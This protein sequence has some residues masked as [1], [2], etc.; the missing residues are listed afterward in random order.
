VEV[1]TKG[2]TTL[3][4]SADG[5]A[6]WVKKGKDAFFGH[7]AYVAVDTEDAFIDTAMARPANKSE[8]KQ[9]RRVVRSLPEG[10]EGVL[11]DKGFASTA[12]R[13][14]LK[15]KRLDDLIQYRATTPRRLSA[16][17]PR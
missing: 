17:R 12:N 3:K 9:F 6:R 15:R 7:R 10:V 4:D 11:A 13:Q 1:D 2:K 5:E 8:T 16:G 14:N